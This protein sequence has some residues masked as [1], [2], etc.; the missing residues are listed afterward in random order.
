MKI[1]RY[2]NKQESCEKVK[3]ELRNKNEKFLVQL[4]MIAKE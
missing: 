2:H 3:P 1:L 4:F